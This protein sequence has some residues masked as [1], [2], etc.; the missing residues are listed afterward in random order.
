MPVFTVKEPTHLIDFLK[1][2][3]PD[4]GAGTL[5]SRLKSG[6]VQVGGMAIR[7][8]ATRLVPGDLVEV[9]P[10]PPEA[11]GFFPT[12]LGPP[13]LPLLH[14]DPDLLAVD[15]PP[16]LL[17]V[18]SAREKV[19]TAIRLMREWLGELA[20][21]EAEN[22]HA[23]HRLDRD[24][25]GVLL[26][27]RSLEVKRE[28]ASAWHTYSKI[29]LALV[30]GRPRQEEGEINLPLWEDKG[31]FVRVARPEE[32]WAATTRYRLLA[33]RGGRSLLEVEL[34]T[35]R[36]HQIRVH[37]AQLGCPIVGDRRYG[38]SRGT[39]LAL[40][41]KS[42]RLTHPRSGRETYIESPPPPFFSRHWQP[43]RP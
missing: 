33:S 15:K 13:P 14:A 9:L 8:G 12:H 36:K 7:S 31:L 26:L 3:L 43:R 30:D 11:G 18:A 38:F 22:L 23:A 10:R 35:G 28:L 19:L 24:A 29:Y 17:S 40:H 37:L 2:S 41:A 25:S 20:P 34:V 39:R 16:G 1:A 6:L 21:E 42:L 5:K 32:G 27:A 4:W